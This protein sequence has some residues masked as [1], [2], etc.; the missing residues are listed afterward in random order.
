MKKI[1][2]FVISAMMMLTLT[3]SVFAEQNTEKNSI[4]DFNQDKIVYDMGAGWNLGNQLE[5]V[6]GDGIPKETNWGNPVITKEL[7]T[8]VKESGF[9]TIRI[10][11]SYF[12]RIGEGPDYIIEEA[13]LDRIQEVVDYAYSQGMYVIMNIHGD[14]Y[15][16][17]DNSWILLGDYN[18]IRDGSEES[19]AKEQE[20]VDIMVDKFAKVWRQIANRF[21]DYDEHLIFESMNEMQSKQNSVTYAKI[22]YPVLNRLNQTFV[23]TVRQADGEYN[24][25]RWLEIP[26]WFC[27]F[28]YILKDQYG[29][30]IPTDEYRSAEIPADQKRIMLAVHFYEP[31][32]FCLGD[33]NSSTKWG[34]KKDIENINNK[35]K[36]VSD[37]F[38]S[39]G[40]PIVIGEYGSV[41]KQ[42]AD[43][44]NLACRV[45]MYK[46][47]CTKALEYGL[48]PVCWDNGY[49][50]TG[51]PFGLFD[52]RNCTV[53]FPEIVAAATGV[54]SEENIA[55][56]KFRK[57]LP[58][59][60]QL[61][62]DEYTAES[63]TAL[64]N[65]V[66]NAENTIL[67]S[68]PSDSEIETLYQNVLSAIKKLVKK[69]AVTTAKTPTN[70]PVKT[71]TAANTRNPAAV[72]KDKAAAE[73]LMKQAKITKLNVKSK[74]K[75]KITATWKKVKK[76][77]GYE[78]QLSANKKFKKSKILYDK[79][80]SKKKLVIKNKKIKSGKKYY[81]RVRAYATYKDV[82]NNAVKVYS[83][84][85]K[86]LRKVTVK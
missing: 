72:A 17:I 22:Y 9:N 36:S 71:T 29:F 33:V 38:V 11:V 82:N 63:W 7:I 78:V 73:K 6:N 47:I 79:F 10:P 83:A 19:L 49:V 18:D 76:A 50:N 12:L 65:T 26:G 44:N 32:D 35:F 61:N 3:S 57:R 1:L 55:L 51:D 25:K 48:I 8:L 62:Q 14:G 4:S 56:D 20:R 84:W 81:V 34:S 5:A 85:N 46:E 59:L 45:A 75:K 54:Y 21:A 28:D 52:R 23:D 74:T 16:T 24:K 80:T 53:A 58:E 86:K 66:T 27:G 67:N 43:P 39:Q 68:N 64:Q 60:K 40:Y 41:N 42:N 77:K 15:Y 2:S 30:K 69:S 13:W 70:A 31:F 37:K